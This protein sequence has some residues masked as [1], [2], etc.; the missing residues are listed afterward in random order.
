MFLAAVAAA[1]CPRETVQSG[2]ET[3][4]HSTSFSYSHN[5]SNRD[6]SINI[7]STGRDHGEITFESFESSRRCAVTRGENYQ[8]QEEK[9]GRRR[10]LHTRIGRPPEEEA[11]RPSERTIG[12]FNENRLSR[13]N[14]AGEERE[15]GSGPLDAKVEKGEKRNN[16][17][18]EEILLR[19][20]SADDKEI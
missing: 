7:T 14:S 11:R 9:G 16:P 12:E 19:F 17:I 13:T 1:G 3:S 2:Q 15:G 20:P 8:E 10:Q 6:V 18:A 4:R 5:S